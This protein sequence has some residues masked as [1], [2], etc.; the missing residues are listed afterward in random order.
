M[1]T[2]VGQPPL[3]LARPRGPL[4]RHWS[5]VLGGALLALAAAAAL[6]APWLGTVDP[7]FI[8]PARRLRPPSELH[9]FGTDHLGRDL[10]SRVLYGARAS[11]L[12]GA[13]VAAA[14]IAAGLVLGLAAGSSRWVDAV[15]M[16]V[17]DGMMAIP[18]VLLA[19][20]LMALTRASIG[21]VIL[22]IAVTEVPRVTRLVRSVVLQ[23][24]EQPFVEA[25]EA[26]GTSRLATLRRHVVP[27]TLAPL[28]VQASFICSSAI[29]TEAI[30]SFIGAGT[31]NDVATWGNIIA[32]GRA[33]FQIRPHVI[34]FPSVFL[35][36][37]VLAINLLGDGL[38][39]LL[40]PRLARGL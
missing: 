32:E 10:Y 17:M 20:A 19:I 7:E 1:L 2:A 38:R 14:A 12:V 9:W 3:R 25:A 16:R 15:V 33:S 29:L 21:N 40:D 24:R 30:L 28:I 26:C 6:L 36:L 35:S 37:T 5:I 27:N 23:I 31:P 18:A 39:D 34:L 4:R 13:A 11:L 22:A 8:A